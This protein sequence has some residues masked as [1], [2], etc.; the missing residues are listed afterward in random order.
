MVLPTDIAVKSVRL[1][2]TGQPFRSPLKFGSVVIE[3]LTLL[4]ATVEVEN[5][6][7][8]VAAGVGNV[9]LSFPWACPEG[10]SS[11][12]EKDRAMR[13]VAE[14]YASLTE[15]L[16]RRYHPID[17]FAS[18]QDDLLKAAC[19]VDASMPC[20]AALVAASPI[21]CAVH[22]AFG[23]VNRICTYDGYGKEHCEYD[24]SRHLGEGYAGKYIGDFL[25]DR[26]ALSLPIFHLVGGL[27]PLCRS[28]VSDRSPA[29]P[30][31]STLEEWIHREGIYCFK[32]KLR[33]NDLDWDH[34]RCIAV[35]D[36][37]RRARKSMGGDRFYLSIDTNEVCESPEYCIELLGRLER[38]DRDVFNAILY[39]EQP[40]GRDL[41]VHNH[42]MRSLASLK[43]VLVDESASS[44]S[45]FE[46]A[47]EL[48][49]S[50]IALKTC[51]C[52][53]LSLLEFAKAKHEGL[54]YSVQD[55]TNCGCGLVHS[56]GFA[57]RIDPILGVECNSR[58]FIPG[59]NHAVRA[60]HRGLVQ[61]SKGEI[62]TNSLEE[63]GLGCRAAPRR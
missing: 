22:D 44:L 5:G 14:R 23:R 48:G 42:D 9:L 13:T 1:D 30:T 55:L 19:E 46:R 6:R 53:S 26:Y 36:V 16:S 2:F 62:R 58:Q 11:P 20:L 51:K 57:A 49:W 12:E 61:P 3:S 60:Q 47:V 38:A 15:G 18:T 41:E 40:T 43:P 33:G 54:V 32:L 10:A 35:A 21:D 59:A 52:L 63:I 7:G 34:N 17:L 45:D 39:L 8:S 29:D 25:Q 31:P 50:G 37:A 4:T 27:D 56:V 28:E 24:L